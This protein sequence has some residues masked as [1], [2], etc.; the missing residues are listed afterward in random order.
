M[1]CFF[2]KDWWIQGE[3]G[4]LHC[5]VEL[6]E[7]HEQAVGRTSQ[8]GADQKNKGWGRSAASAGREPSLHRPVWINIKAVS[9][10]SKLASEKFGNYDKAQD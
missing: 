10:N 4:K 9:L 6:I 2:S 8:A 1:Q 3:T 7:L 5:L